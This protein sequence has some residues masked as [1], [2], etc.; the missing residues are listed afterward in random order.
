M[1]SGDFSSSKIAEIQLKADAMWKDSQLQNQYKAEVGT[2]LAIQKEQTASIKPIDDGKTNYDVSINWIDTCAIEE[3]DCEPNCDIDA[4]ES[5]TKKQNLTLVQCK[6]VK[7]AVDEDELR[8]S[9]FSQEEVFAQQ[10]LAA[11]Q[12]LDEAIS[13]QAVLFLAA[14]DSTN[15][16]SS[17]YPTA[18]NTTTIPAAEYNRKLIAYF[19]K[20]GIINRMR[21]SYMIDGGELFI[22]Y[23]NAL[24]DSGNGE[25]K[26]DADRYNAVRMYWDLFGFAAAG[27]TQDDF[28]INKASVA[29]ASKAKYLGNTTANPLYY[30]GDVNQWRFSWNSKNIPGVVYDAYKTMKCVLKNGQDHIVHVM[31]LQAKFDY[32][33]NPTNCDGS[34]GILSFTKA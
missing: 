17:P 1:A 10:M 27:I 26:G 19:I 3:A 33:L 16:L 28:L 24:F 14:N 5:E 6:E 2:V 7:F 9:I 23:Q 22:D 32:F 29:F 25:G 4:P 18:G 8:S 15:Q 21:N 34:T 20:A 13:K 11:S 12:K 30:G 31:K